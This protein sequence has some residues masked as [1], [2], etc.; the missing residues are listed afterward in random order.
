MSDEIKGIISAPPEISARIA[1]RGMDGKDGQ[2]GAPGADGI[3]PHI[4][5]NGNWYLGE[6]DTG[7]KA[8]GQD[9]LDCKDGKDGKDGA[10]GHTP[11]RGTDYWTTTDQTAIVADVLA[12]LPDWD[13][14]VES[15]LGGAS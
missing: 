7:V 2:D 12:A 9:G 8:E 6:T 14:L 3:T 13:G 10:D 15:I 1:E 11:V 5:V 4:G